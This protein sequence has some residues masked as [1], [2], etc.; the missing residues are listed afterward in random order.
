MEKQR[1]TFSIEVPDDPTKN[2][3][4]DLGEMYHFEIGDKIP[5]YTNSSDPKK[6]G[7]LKENYVIKKIIIDDDENHLRLI[8]GIEPENI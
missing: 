7:K 3:G 6:H 1:K 8:C 4:T 2:T 5:C